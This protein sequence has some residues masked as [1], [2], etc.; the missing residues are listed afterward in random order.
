MST[1]TT[2]LRS[3]GGRVVRNECDDR[4]TACPECGGLAPVEAY[5]V[6]EDGHVAGYVCD[7][8]HWSLR[9]LTAV[10]DD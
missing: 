3:R 8:W 9:V 10:A 6:D 4:P 5:L 2:A 7:D 1:V